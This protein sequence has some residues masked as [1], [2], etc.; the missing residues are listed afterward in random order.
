MNAH[1]VA[2]YGKPHR[3][4]KEHYEG[5][6]L[7]AHQVGTRV[8]TQIELSPAIADT[9]VDVSGLTT[10]R[11]QWKMNASQT[12]KPQSQQQ[13]HRQCEFLIC[14]SQ[15]SYKEVLGRQ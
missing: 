1:T 4:N 12:P 6:R 8:N 15:S 10:R 2:I 14:R 11:R 7:T 13:P 5:M 3:R 9:T